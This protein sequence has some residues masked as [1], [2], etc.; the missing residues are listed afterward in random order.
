MFLTTMACLLWKDHGLDM[1]PEDEDAI[2][3]APQTR[4]TNKELSNQGRV[5]RLIT[6]NENQLDR[7]IE[8]QG[9]RLVERIHT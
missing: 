3:E 9:E 6:R 2:I 4:E 1:R 7:E 8:A 5:S